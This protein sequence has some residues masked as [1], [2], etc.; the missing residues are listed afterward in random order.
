MQTCL[1]YCEKKYHSF[2]RMSD[3]ICI[4]LLNCISRCLQMIFFVIVLQIYAINKRTY[5]TTKEKLIIQAFAGRP[6]CI[7]QL[8][9]WYSACF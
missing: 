4:D 3:D 1:L 7:H 2:S 9:P 5:E 6:R 8:S